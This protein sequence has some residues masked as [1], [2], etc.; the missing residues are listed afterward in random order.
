VNVKPFFHSFSFLGATEVIHAVESHQDEPPCQQA[1]GI[2]AD[3]CSK[4][5]SSKA[6]VETYRTRHLPARVGLA[7]KD[8]W[9]TIVNSWSKPREKRAAKWEMV[10]PARA[11]TRSRTKEAMAPGVH[12][13]ESCD[14]SGRMVPGV[15]RVP[16]SP[17]PRSRHGTPETLSPAGCKARKGAR[18]GGSEC[19]GQCRGQA[20]GQPERVLTSRDL[21]VV[22]LR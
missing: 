20:C 5:T 22:N 9:Q 7:S 15:E 11:G 1:R 12:G 19:P 2:H 16:T 3:S 6:R 17:A 4:G 10:S 8:S 13:M 14:P 18:S 21:S